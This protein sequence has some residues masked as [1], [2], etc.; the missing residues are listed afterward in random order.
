MKK[1]IRRITASLI[2]ALCAVS[3][4]YA[5]DRPNIYKPIPGEDFRICAMSDNGTFVISQTAGDQEVDNPQPAGG[6]LFNL[7]TKQ[8]TIIPAPYGVANVSDV[9]DDGI[10]VGSCDGIPAYWNPLNGE[11]TK[12]QVSSGTD[13]GNFLA[14]TPDGKYAVGYMGKS[15]DIMFAQP[16]CY[17]L[18]TGEMVQIT[19]LPEVDLNG[20]NNNQNVFYGISPDGRYILGQMSQSYW[21]P[22]GLMSYVY[23]VQ[24]QSWTP[25][26]FDYDPATKKYSPQVADLNFIINQSMSANGEWVCGTAYMVGN[27]GDFNGGYEY[28]TPYRYNV[29]SKQIEIFNKENDHDIAGNRITNDGTILGS[30][31]TDNPYPTA[32]I[33]SGNFFISLDQVLKQVY[34]TDLYTAVGDNI[35]GAFECV[36]ADGLKAAMVTY[37]NCYVIEMN[38]PFAAAA[39]KV[40][41]LSN[42]SLSIPQQSTI[43]KISEIKLTFDREIQCKNLPS[44][45]G[46]YKADGSLVRNATSTV[47]S[48]SNSHQLSVTFRTQTLDPDEIYHVKIPAD[49]IWLAEDASVKSKE[50][51]LTYF[52]RSADAVQ[53]VSITPADGAVLSELDYTSNFITV[54]FDAEVKASTDGY[55]ALY[56]ADDNTLLANML[57]T[58]SGE[59]AYFFT[60][61]TYMLYYGSNYR[62]EIGEGTVTDLSGSGANLPITLNYKGSYIRQLSDDDKFLFKSNCDNYDYFIF[63]SNETNT[64]NSVAQSWGF[65]EYNS[66]LL[67]RDSDEDVDQALCAHSMFSPAG[68]SD[69][70]LVI[71]QTYI[72]DDKATLCF[73]AQSYKKSKQ[74]RLKV[75][76]YECDMI[77]NYL[78]TPITEDIIA[79]GDL[80]FDEILS[81]GANEETLA[82][83]WTKYIIDL[84]D[85]AS[86]N[87]YIAFVN[88]NT[89]QS[90]IFIDNVQ[91]I[92]DLDFLLTNS[93]PEA[94]VALDEVTVAGI[95]SPGQSNVEYSGI[96]LTLLDAD[97]SI[98]DRIS[99]P[100]AR[101]DALSPYKFQFTKPL[102]LNIGQT[103]SYFI[104][105]AIGDKST[106]LKYSIKDLAFKIDKRVV[107]EEYSGRECGNCPLGILAVD[108]L[109]AIYHDNFIPVVIRTYN[110]D[111]HG[112]YVTNYSSYLGLDDFGAPSGRIN[113]NAI[114]APMVQVAGAYQF[115]GRG[116]YDS[117]GEENYTWADAVS[118]E[119]ATPAELSLDLS[120]DYNEATREISVPVTVRSALDMTQTSIYLHAVVVEDNL[121]VL[122]Q[123]NNFY[124][125]SDPNIGEWGV[126]GQYG[127]NYVNFFLDDVARYVLNG[128]SYGGV[129]MT[130]SDFTAGESYCETFMTTLPEGAIDDP[131][132][133]H[134][135][136]M[137]IDGNSRK[138]INANVCKF[139]QSG[140]SS[141]DIAKP[142]VSVSGNII[143]VSGEGALDVAVYSP[144]G[145]LISHT[146]GY[147]FTS[148]PTGAYKG[149]AIVKVKTSNGTFAHKL[150][151]K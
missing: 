145:M 80:V 117:T 7:T 137:A 142:S 136:V 90:A 64:P 134:V 63:W 41:L 96:Q 38:E 128:S 27:G 95:I 151:L 16:M 86:K 6:T 140:L 100:D 101:I 127:K 35:T 69:D 116:S 51:Q 1:S 111:A 23:D 88:N 34:N 79:N 67:V 141:A 14:V 91:I 84:K 119:L 106:S 122:R 36:S 78:S 66:W 48:A 52:G 105:V 135:V 30:T 39:A 33:R 3:I 139:G 149:V 143:N 12:L 114:T 59:K 94:V 15:T 45:V 120:V 18:S 19:N 17:D 92:R 5:Q 146:K 110:G 55:C 124:T 68:T 121:L 76:V 46:L 75:Y 123:T 113:R 26:G 2:A 65:T 133:C 98:I 138:V 11:W 28:R 147:S 109:K 82:G 54:T 89:D 108:N 10:V 57:C 93:T 31:P 60:D 37:D 32:M 53:P 74:D 87:I 20:E 112:R 150:V 148:I 8:S 62:V 25:I 129:A 21:L 99:D 13:S 144:S 130:T 4:G 29:I 43:T 77:Y 83:D 115:Y 85:Y 71:P 58:T 118:D 61:G 102:P 50:I 49:Y 125:V 97:G 104:E 73:D 9:T 81:P 131:Q 40:D 126:G 22:V 56:N 70:W 107:L 103:S 47:I 42:F 24:Q 72:P 44:A 132:N